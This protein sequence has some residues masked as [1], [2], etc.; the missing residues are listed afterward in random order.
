MD[1]YDFVTAVKFGTN[2][3]SFLGPLS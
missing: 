1:S 3:W 2:G